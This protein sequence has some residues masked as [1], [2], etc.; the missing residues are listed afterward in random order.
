ME[1]IDKHTRRADRML[2][3]GKAQFI[4]EA[5]VVRSTLL[6]LSHDREGFVQFLMEQQEGNREGAEKMIRCSREKD[7]DGIF[8]IIIARMEKELCSYLP[9]IEDE[10]KGSIVL[11]ENRMLEMMKT[12]AE[13][14]DSKFL[15]QGPAVA[16]GILLELFG[17]LVTLDI[18]PEAEL[19][20]G[21]HD[22]IIRDA[23]IKVSKEG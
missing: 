21:Q 14:R 23:I 10:H 12:G 19:L 13:K 4:K 15:K 18:E 17:D 2:Q 3:K 7:Y 5:R 9:F 16:L 8:S 22:S 6:K 1:V 11:F 20:E